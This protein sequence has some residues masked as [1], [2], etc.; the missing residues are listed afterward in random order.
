METPTPATALWY[1]FNAHM[2][3]NGARLIPLSE[4]RVF[5]STVH[6]LVVTY[7][8]NHHTPGND[9]EMF[10]SY[11]VD[12]L[13]HILGDSDRIT[14]EK[15]N[16][17]FRAAIDSLGLT[18]IHVSSLSTTPSN[19]PSSH[20]QVYND[21]KILSVVQRECQRILLLIQ[22]TMQRLSVVQLCLPPAC[23]NAPRCVLR[24]SD[25]N[26][27][28]CVYCA[29]CEENARTEWTRDR[30]LALWVSSGRQL[31]ARL[32][33]HAPPRNPRKRKRRE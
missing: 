9:D 30:A 29:Y 17:S 11:W 16:T 33:A 15:L 2:K 1:M 23:N 22:E 14:V 8:R 24:K 25:D 7:Y 26:D 19:A 18:D 28:L 5:D 12:C 3:R 32:N 27:L 6:Q 20:P 10:K 13:A 21:V 31:L 4:L